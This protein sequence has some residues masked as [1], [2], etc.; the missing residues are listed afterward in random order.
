MLTI[1]LNTRVL[2]LPEDSTAA[3]IPAIPDTNHRRLSCLIDAESS[4]A[5]DSFGTMNS[6]AGA[7]CA[8]DPVPYR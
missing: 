7:G 5:S 2:S 4:A 6:I 8:G 1:R 3:D